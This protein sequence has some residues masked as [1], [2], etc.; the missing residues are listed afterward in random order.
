MARQHM[1]YI[2]LPSGDDVPVFGQGTW[3][4]GERSSDIQR[5]VQTLRHGIERGLSLIDTAEMYADGGAE[6]VVGAAIKGCRDDVFLVS[7]VLPGNASAQGTI[8]ACEGSL[9]RMGTEY[10]D[11]YL[12]HWRGHVPLEETV[13]ALEDLVE[14]GKIGQWGVSNFDVDDLEELMTIVDNER[15]AT[16]QVLYNLS[17]RGIEYD[18]LPWCR[19]NS[20]PVMAYSPI[21]QARLLEHPA[22]VEVAKRH[23]ATPAQIAL[24]WV[25][26]DHNIITIPKASSVE[27]MIENI[28]SLSIHLEHE[29]YVTLD[30]AFPP[31]SRKKPLEML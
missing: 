27:H 12:L 31:P 30:A 4:M 28:G 2:T 16:N 19:S 29:D 18:L 21:E 15:I 11:L 7:K 25:L 14:Q 5:E 20:M 9:K 13:N 1:R 26:R 8:A 10:I 24:A 17:R 22:L 6:R 3:F 23:H